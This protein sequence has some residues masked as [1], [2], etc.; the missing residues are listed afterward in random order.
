MTQVVKATLGIRSTLS[1]RMYL[2]IHTLHKTVLQSSF[3]LRPSTW[4]GPKGLPGC[5]CLPCSH[6]SVALNSATLYS[7]PLNLETGD[8]QLALA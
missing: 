4:S 3:A 7:T 8:R 5:T 6:F 2:Y 1:I